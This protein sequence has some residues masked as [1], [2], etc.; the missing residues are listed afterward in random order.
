MSM[1]KAHVRVREAR[2]KVTA[3]RLQVAAPASA[4][5]ARGERHPVA[6]LGMSAG[7]GFAMAQFNV[8]PLRIPGF[9]GLLGGV[10]AEVA[11]LGANLIAGNAD[12]S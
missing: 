6:M 9:G 5:L 1:F 4:L 11:A 2:Q 10:V 12:H 3:A 7:V 8:H